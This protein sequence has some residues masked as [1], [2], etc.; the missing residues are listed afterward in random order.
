M[1]QPEREPKPLRPLKG[2]FSP[3]TNNQN[4]SVIAGPIN[5][6]FLEGDRTGMERATALSVGKAEQKIGSLTKKHS[7]SHIPATCK[8]LAACQSAPWIWLSRRTTKKGRLNTKHPKRCAKPSLGTSRMRS[9]SHWPHL[10]SRMVAMWSTALPQHWRARG[11]LPCLKQSRMPWKD[12]F[13]R[14]RW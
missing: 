9:G 6:A 2:W 10:P 11:I 14:I 5:I 7:S 12:D 4:G 1:T 13:Q 8:T 3:N